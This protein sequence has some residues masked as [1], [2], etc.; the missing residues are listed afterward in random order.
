LGLFFIKSTNILVNQS[1]VSQALNIS[2][3]TYKDSSV[4]YR[5]GDNSSENLEPIFVAISKLNK[6][7]VNEISS[8]NNIINGKINII[9]AHIHGICILLYNKTNITAYYVSYKIKHLQFWEFL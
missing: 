8:G 9:I 5:V 3:S 7:T 6:A 2:L 1:V 4:Y